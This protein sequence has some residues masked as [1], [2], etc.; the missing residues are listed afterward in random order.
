MA[1][2]YREEMDKLDDTKKTKS[3]K[4]KKKCNYTSCKLSAT[5]EINGHYTCPFHFNTDFPNQVTVSITQNFRLIQHYSRMVKW[6]VK[7]W[8][9]QQSWLLNNK[10]LNML[11]DEIPSVYINRFYNWLL[12]KVADDATR[13][14]EKKVTNE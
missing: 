11:Q 10:S 3:V 7:D 9:D 6:T 1:N 2:N 8:R 12:N 13:L 5:T 14:I 4:R